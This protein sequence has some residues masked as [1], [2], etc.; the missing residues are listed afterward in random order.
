MKRKYILSGEATLQIIF[1]YV[2]YM[3]LILRFTTLTCFVTRGIAVNDNEPVS[4]RGLVQ[5]TLRH[6]WLLL[7]CLARNTNNTNK[8]HSLARKQAQLI[9]MYS[10]T[11]RQISEIIVLDVCYI[12]LC[13]SQRLEYSKVCFKCLA[14]V[15]DTQI[16]IVIHKEF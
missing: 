16:D 6:T 11:F 13:S 10:H 15:K 2:F 1:S 4:C 7:L 8:E 9:N 5:T 14:K 12:T 3:F